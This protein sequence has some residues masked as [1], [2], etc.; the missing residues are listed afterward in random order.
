MKNL[1]VIPGWC[2]TTGRKPYY[3][4]CEIARKKGYN[5]IKKNL[6]WDESLLKQIFPI[7]KNDVIFGFSL[8]AVFACMIARKYPHK[9]LIAASMSPVL[10]LPEQTLKIL[11][12]EVAADCRR[13]R[14]GGVK[15]VYLYGEGE[16]DKSLDKIKKMG[17]KIVPNCCYQ[18]NSEY[19]Q[20]ISKEL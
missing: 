2:D 9:K 12:K 7:S 3:E 1:Y 6:D 19:V 10:D 18:L 4:L 14:Y 20:H 5:V 11:G 8:G 16:I 17:I 15:A 13:F